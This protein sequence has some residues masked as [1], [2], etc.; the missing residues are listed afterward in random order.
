MWAD[1]AWRKIDSIVRISIEENL[2]DKRPLGKTKLKRTW[3][4]FDQFKLHFGG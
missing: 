4:R 2:I 1:R 3:E